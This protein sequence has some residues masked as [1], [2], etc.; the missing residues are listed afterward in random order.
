[1]TL[2][3]CDRKPFYDLDL[4]CDL[5]MILTSCVTVTI[6]MTLTSLEICPCV[7]VTLSMTLTSCVIFPFYDLDLVCDPDPFYD[8][9]L[10][11]DLTFL[12]P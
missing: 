11:C 3:S 1:M 5:S 2:T 9:D 7:T 10:V 4:M 12:W 6:S 8:H